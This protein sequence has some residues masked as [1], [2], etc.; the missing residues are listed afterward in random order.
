[1]M[2]LLK[3]FLVKGKRES[4]YGETFISSNANVHSHIHKVYQGV[5][6]NV[7]QLYV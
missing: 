1:M 4:Y 5:K 6:H 2:L 3:C 7:S